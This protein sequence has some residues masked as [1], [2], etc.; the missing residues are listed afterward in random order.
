MRRKAGKNGFRRGLRVAAALLLLSATGAGCADR[1]PSGSASPDMPADDTLSDQ[2]HEYEGDTGTFRDWLFADMYFESA[3]GQDYFLSY[4][5]ADSAPPGKA[6]KSKPSSGK[7][8]APSAKPSPS[9]DS[10]KSFFGNTDME[11]KISARKV[12]TAPFQIHVE[13]LQMIERPEDSV[14]ISEEMDVKINGR[15]QNGDKPGGSGWMFT[16][17]ADYKVT[18]KV[19]PVQG[20]TL[21]IS[22]GL[23][24]W[25]FGLADAVSLKD[26]Q[27]PKKKDPTMRWTPPENKRV[28]P[29]ELR[30]QL[31]DPNDP[32][33]GLQLV[34]TVKYSAVF[35]VPTTYRT[36]IPA[37]REGFLSAYAAPEEDPSQFVSGDFGFK[38]GETTGS[39]EMTVE[40]QID[41]MDFVSAYIL[42]DGAR[43]GPFGGLLTSDEELQIKLKGKEDYPIWGV[44]T[45]NPS[46]AVPDPNQDRAKVKAGEKSPD[47]A[48]GQWLIL[49][50]G[51]KG[52]PST[53]TSIEVREN[54]IFYEEGELWR[55]VE[56]FDLHPTAKLTFPKDLTGD[57]VADPSIFMNVSTLDI[58]YNKYND[59]LFVTG[60]GFF[61][62][63]LERS[64]TQ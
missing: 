34:P 24:A 36:Y 54:T 28:T 12:R 9:P 3:L 17:A 30:A 15:K 64:Q 43:F 46:A 55:H 47:Y 59:T 37:D 38:P 60:A 23:A 56:T 35:K 25:N 1:P 13:G 8:S 20:M 61:M 19:A 32:K 42:V 39:G 22:V 62:D 49:T 7:E 44:W 26:L 48:E 57:G 6:G 5:I 2:F 27:P 52:Q 63:S 41:S 18:C 31:L 11:F 45:N 50:Q 53:Y 16:I 4:Q 33:K 10:E 58:T 29:E 14:L 21:D 51:K 40:I